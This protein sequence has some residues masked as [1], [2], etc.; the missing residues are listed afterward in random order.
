MIK[1]DENNDDKM[2]NK[3]LRLNCLFTLLL[4]LLLITVGCDVKEVNDAESRNNVSNNSYITSVYNIRLNVSQ[5]D[6]RILFN[7]NDYTEDNDEYRGWAL[8][9]QNNTDSY[10][11]YSVSMYNPYDRMVT[12]CIETRGSCVIP[13]YINA[14]IVKIKARESYKTGICVPLNVSIHCDN[15][16]IAVW[17]KQVGIYLVEYQ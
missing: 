5:N 13:E 2:K 7:E 1:N 9:N 10:L 8:I 3:N 15:F 16:S 14:N 11:V 6:L 17:E 4:L 12:L